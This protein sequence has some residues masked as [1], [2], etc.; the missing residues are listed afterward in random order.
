VAPTI[1]ADAG[2]SLFVQIL[3]VSCSDAGDCVAVGHYLDDSFVAHPLLLSQSDSVWSPGA[4]AVLPFGGTFPFAAQETAACVPAGDCVAAVGYTDTA[5]NSVAATVNGTPDSPATPT[6]T[7]NAPPPRLELG[8]VIPGMNLSAGLAGGSNESGTLSFIVFGPQANPPQSCAAGG[9]TVD[10]E[11]VAGDG[12]YTS[13]AAYA[14]A[15]PG[16]YWWYAS[17]GGD[18]G[19][20]PANSACGAAMAGTV[21]TAPTL[22]LSAPPLGTTGIAINGSAVTAALSDVSSEAGGTITVSVFGPQSS[23]PTSCAASGAVVGTATVESGGTY[24]PAGSFTPGSAGDYWWYASYG[25]DSENPS[26]GSPCGA[27]MAE[28]TVSDPPGPTAT[29]PAGPTVS[30]GA[31]TSAPPTPALAEPTAATSSLAGI[32]VRGDQI[33]LTVACRGT[34]HQNCSD[35]LILSVTERVSGG[36]VVGLIARRA[37]RAERRVVTVGTRRVVIAAG[38]IRRM[39]ISLNMTGHQLL[40][41]YRLLTARLELIEG[42]EHQT[43]VVRF[44]ADLLNRKD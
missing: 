7:M 30:L 14:P 5:G 26:A 1:P 16:T 28:T 41:T 35:T 19:D 36:R 13:R 38:Q 3:S 8:A 44:R 24:A 15:D 4:E 43:R 20:G 10:T 18:L 21:V 34:A 23:P 40:A 9:T 33:M 32:R 6:V 37:T 39:S 11:P 29:A 22:S 12:T 42:A 31:I 2:A 17:Y 27:Q 25:G